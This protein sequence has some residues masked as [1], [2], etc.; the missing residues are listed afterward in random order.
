MRINSLTSMLE[1]NAAAIVMAGRA[2]L[3]T[4][5]DLETDPTVHVEGEDTLQAGGGDETKAPEGDEQKSD[6]TEDSVAETFVP[7]VEV[8]DELPDD[9]PDMRSP[10]ASIDWGFSDWVVGTHMFV[11]AELAQRARG[12]LQG[13]R[14]DKDGKAN[15]KK[16]QTFEIKG[17]VSA[18]K[19][20]PGFKKGDIEV[21]RRA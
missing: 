15:G 20:N 11:P 12:A 19:R 9:L 16:F 7:T 10:A 14:T 2:N 3:K 1:I 21:W 8:A 13:A 5:D 4:V 18:E 6:A 17:V